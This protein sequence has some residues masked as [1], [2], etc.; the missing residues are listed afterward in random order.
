MELQLKMIGIL[1][2]LLSLLH[3]V[4]PKYFSWK[5]ELAALSLMNRQM[6]YVHTFFIALFVLLNG[7]LCFFYAEELIYTALGKV[8]CLG[9]AIFWGIRLLFQFFVYAPKLWMGKPFE[10]TMHILFSLLWI[11]LTVVFAISYWI[12]HK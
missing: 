5:K 3:L 2:S 4:F 1:L 12:I 8:I 11:Y 9:L 6:M 10:T 7:L